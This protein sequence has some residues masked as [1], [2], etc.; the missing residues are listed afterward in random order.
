MSDKKY[1]RILFLVYD[2][3]QMKIS[4]Y[5]C[6]LKESEPM[7]R[8]TLNDHDIKALR[9][10]IDAAHNIVLTCH[11]RPDG[12]AIGSTL[13]L[14]KMLADEGKNVAV[15]TPDT[16]PRSLWFLTKGEKMVPHS[17]YPEY[18]ERLVAEADLILCCDF[19]D[20]KRLDALAPYV[21]ASRAK[22]VLIDHHREPQAFADITF[23][24]PEMSSTC[25][26]VFRILAALGLY[27]R[28]SREAA[29]PLLTGLV[30]DT[31]NFSVN[32]SQPDIYE[33]LQ[34]LLDKD[35]NKQEIVRE[36]LELR[37]LNSLK[38]QAFAISER[39]EVFE[40]HKAALICL[41]KADLDRFHYEKGDTEGLV[42]MPLEVRGIV[43]SIY[44]REDPDCIKVSARSVDNF[45]VNMICKD[46][47]GGG[48]HLMAAGGE[49]KGTLAECRATL[50]DHMGRYDKYLP[51]R[52][53]KKEN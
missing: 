33:I 53:S 15:V 34:R 8:K 42:N 19:N 36:A 50:M 27:D 26:L 39:L 32:C 46:L 7:L 29:R 23:S 49:F 44:M 40:A 20:L 30:T 11:V 13:G 25:E 14:S 17:Q 3:V 12:D 28:M 48:G 16:A 47:F 6:S 10:A 51:T 21:E 43:Y 31:R 24:E 5:L 4:C 18:A 37:S 1:R 52:K 35:L 2:W 38:L 41:D 9:E 22:K 45:P